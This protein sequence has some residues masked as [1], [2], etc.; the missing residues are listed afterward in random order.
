M[1]PSLWPSQAWSM[2]ADSF[3]DSSGTLGPLT[4]DFLFSPYSGRRQPHR[5]VT[6]GFLHGGIFHLCLNM[7]ALTQMPTWLET[8]LGWQLFS[9]TYL[10][11]IITGNLFHQRSAMDE[12]LPCLG[13]S[14]GIVALLGL[15]FVALGKMGNKPA[16][17]QILRSIGALLLIGF[18]FPSVSN[19]SH[20]GG[21]LAGCVMGL[22]FSPGYRK[23]YSLRRKNTVQLDTAPRDFRQVMGFGIVPK[24]NPPLPLWTLWAVALVYASTNTRVQNAVLLIWKGLCRPGS[25]S[26][27]RMW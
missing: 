24:K 4:R 6:S 26:T 16:S 25:V 13:S 8:G 10:V 17:A 22:L 9:T 23:S 2:F 14:G 3:I 21:F 12:F 27:N 7:A 5:F 15:S 20:L 19:A 1:Y 18:M 11:G